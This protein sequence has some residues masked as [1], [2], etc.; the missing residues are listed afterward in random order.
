[1]SI[2][3]IQQLVCDQ[4]GCREAYAAEYGDLSSAVEQRKKARELGWRRFGG[5][6]L[7]PKHRQ[8]RQPDHD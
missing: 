2:L 3:T 8:E 5:R 4:P 1:M 6:D 7:C